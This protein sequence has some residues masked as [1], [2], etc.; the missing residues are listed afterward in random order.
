MCSN[1]RT[2]KSFSVT[3]LPASTA[4]KNENQIEISK[5]NGSDEKLRKGKK[6]LIAQRRALV[7]DFVKK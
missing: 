2:G 5:A 7:E 3:A 6:I 4:S 1:G